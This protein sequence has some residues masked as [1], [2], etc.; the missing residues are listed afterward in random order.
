MKLSPLGSQRAPVA[1]QK[2]WPEER[3]VPESVVQTFWLEGMRPRRARQG[4]REV[5]PLLLVRQ[6]MEVP[7][8]AVPIVLLGGDADV[9]VIGGGCWACVVDMDADVVI[10]VDAV[11][12]VEES[13]SK[14]SSVDGRGPWDTK[15][16]WISPS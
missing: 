3:Q 12:V 4:L 15:A 7:E 6:L 9:V 2:D 16:P 5:P 13:P 1:L 14:V 10:D 11:V 8:G